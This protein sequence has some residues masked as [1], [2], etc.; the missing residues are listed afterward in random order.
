ME[1]IG[2]KDNQVKIRGYRIE[3]GEIEVALLNHPGLDAAVVVAR[4]G[5]DGAKELVAYIVC[6][7]AISAAELR[8]FLAKALPSSLLP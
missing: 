6:Q 1:F 7:Q 5:S 4:A 3:L 8:A 2:R